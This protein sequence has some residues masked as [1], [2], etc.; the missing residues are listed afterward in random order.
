MNV[1]RMVIYEQRRRVLEGE[2]L[3]EDMRAW[4]DE[5]VESIVLQH[6]AGDYPEE[7]DIDALVSDMASLYDPHL[8]PSE[9]VGQTWTRDALLEE[10]RGDAVDAYE[11][12]EEDLGPELMREVE[13][14]LVLQVVD[15]R[16]REHLDVMEYLR[17]GIHLRAMA[18]KDPL[19]EYRA[20]GHAMFQELSATI[21]EEVLRFLFHLEIEREDAAQLEASRAPS[22][23]GGGNGNLVYEHESLAGSDAIMAAGAAGAAGATAEAVAAVAAPGSGGNGGEQ[24]I[25]SEWDRVGRNDPCPCGSGLKY[26]KCH[27]A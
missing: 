23:N 6:T 3:S 17:E 18:Q 22:A 4:I 24:R 10:F 20:E 9:W 13:R 12:K 11:A 21:R 1:Q 14:Y 25:A 5:L 27:G 7:W 15:A 19:S 26:K 8:D 16:W 2:D